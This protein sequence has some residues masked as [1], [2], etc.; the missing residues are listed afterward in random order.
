MKQ[1]NTLRMRIAQL[2]LALAVVLPAGQAAAGTVISELLYDVPGTDSGQVFV[3]LFG[4]PGTVLDGMWQASTV[5]M[6]ASTR[7]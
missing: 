7:R 5:P 4:T 3:E 2:G 1:E 6:A